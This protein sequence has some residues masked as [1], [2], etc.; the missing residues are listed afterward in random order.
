[1]AENPRLICASADLAEGGTGVR[2]EVEIEGKAVPAF[3]VRAGG[4]A[5]A[6]INRCAHV[7]V[8]LD[9]QP[10]RY[11]DILGLYLIC[12]THGAVYD[13]ASGRC[14]GGPCRGRGGLVPLSVT[15]TDGH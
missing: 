7:P 2:F 3:V 13:P 8:E 14:S 10:G 11:F 4:V 1:M 5:R 9:W 6:Y 12:S 15:E